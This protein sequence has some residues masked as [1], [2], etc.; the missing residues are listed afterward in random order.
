MR[1]VSFKAGAPSSAAVAPDSTNQISTELWTNIGPRPL[2]NPLSGNQAGR[3]NS[4][5]VDPRDS[6]VIFIGTADAGAYRTR[7]GGQTWQGLTDLQASPAIGSVAL[8]PTHPDTVFIGTGDPVGLSGAGILRSTDGGAN[9]TLI[10]QPFASGYGGSRI[11]SI[12]V[13]PT[14]GQLVLAAV[15]PPSSGINKSGIYRSTNGGTTWTQVLPSTFAHQVFFHPTDSSIAFA[16]VTASATDTTSAKSGFYKSIDGGVTWNM[17]PGVAALP[18]STAFALRFA[19]APS[20]PTT[21]YVSLADSTGLIGLYRSSD[22]GVTFTRLAATPNHCSTQCGYSNTITIHPTNPNAIFLGGVRCYRSLDG[23]ATWG[24]IT[25]GY[26]DF[27]AI[28]FSNGGARVFFGNDGG[29]WLI[30]QP[31]AQPVTNSGLNDNLTLTQFYPGISVHP[32]NINIAY[33]GAQD[34]GLHRYTGTAAWANF[35]SFLGGGCGDAGHTAMDYQTPSTIYFG[36][37]KNVIWKTVDGGANFKMS[38]NGIN[39]A[40]VSDFVAPLVMDPV[41]PQ[42]LYYGTYRVYQ[43]NDGAANWTAISGDLTG[44]GHVIA[45]LAVAPSD[46]NVVYSS[47]SDGRVFVTTNATAGVGAN[48]VNHSTGLLNTVYG[49]I[50]IDARDPMIAWVGA[51]NV[52]TAYLYRTNDGGKAWTNLT[53]NL[54]KIPV[55]SLLADPDLSGTLYVG[56][57]LGIFISTD[58]GATFNP[59]ASGLPYVPVTSLVLHRPTRTLRAGTYGRGMWDLAVPLPPA[60]VTTPQGVTNGA[61]F[62]NGPVAPGEIFTIFGA[63]LGPASLIGGTVTNNFVDSS[64]ALVRVL[65]DGVPA[66]LLYV[67]AGQV[68]GIVPYAVYGKTSTQV[69]VEYRGQ[70]SAAVTVPVAPSSPAIFLLDSNRQG[71]ILNQDNSVNGVSKPAAVGDFIVIFGTG[72]GQT[73]PPGVDGKIALSVYP[74]PKLDV[75]VSIGGIDAPVAYA[76][77]APQGV[78]GAFQ[79][80]VQIPAGVNPGSA[81]PVILKVGGVASPVVFM[82]IK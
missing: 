40:D 43:T 47:S 66:P 55:E 12:A 29:V 27:H 37:I 5:A 4:I 74:K 46:P 11:P 28:A 57:D 20:D 42:R 62:L 31:L 22:G 33:G 72:E 3:V 34:T 56:S 32:T 25:P 21:M 36:C 67:L 82:A 51:S 61:S 70:R 54:P 13:A 18:V 7:D 75:S 53:N 39:V 14:N 64:D 59:L 58:Y 44:G 19:L 73:I 16:V 38:Q 23:G 2:L 60:P 76:G 9:F 1:P 81:V 35:G 52:G 78:A 71:A 79:V 45:A 77:A 6:N 26:V 48:W 8:D 10:S 63:A 30:P 68:A 17:L 24:E 41:N 65:F 15:F 69:Q 50:A 80:N 49:S